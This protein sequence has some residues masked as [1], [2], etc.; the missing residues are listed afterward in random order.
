MKHYRLFTIFM[1]LIIGITFTSCENTIVCDCDDPNRQFFTIV[2]YHTN[3]NLLFGDNKR[4]SFDSISVFA[5][6]VRNGHNFRRDF[7]T[8]Q[9]QNDSIFAMHLDIQ[10]V[11]KY[12]ISFDLKDLDTI[13][14]STKYLGG[15]CCG[16]RYI[17]DSLK[18]NGK[19]CDR[20][21]Q[22]ILRK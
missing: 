1:I 4:Y 13:D 12:F 15:G 21:N 14:F 2:D 11:K 17:I 8:E 16:D 18:F 22:W 20:N 6:E 3:S 5:I 9:F 10:N 19:M 7:S